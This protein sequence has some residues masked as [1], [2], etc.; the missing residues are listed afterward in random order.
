MEPTPR[1]PTLQDIAR[2]AGV[3]AMTVS[4]ALKNSPL[5]RPETCRRIQNIARDMGWRPNPLVSALMSHLGRQHQV[6]STVNLAILDPRSEDYT[7]NGLYVIGAKRQAAEL[8]YAIEVFPYKP[9][10]TSPARLRDILLARG[11]RGVVL[12]PVPTAL[13]EIAFDFTGFAAVTIGYSVASPVLPRVA[14]DIQNTV[15]TALRH[16]ES[17]GYQRVGLIMADDANRRML[18]LY[19]GA[20][21]TYG[22][23]FARTMEAKELILPDENFSPANLKKI[24][25]WIKAHKIQ[26][27]LTSAFRLYDALIHAGVRIPDDFAFVH[28]HK[29]LDPRVTSIDQ[30]RDYVGHKAVD[31]VTAMIQRNESCPVPY[32]Q[33]V[34]TPSILHKGD[35]SPYYSASRVAPVGRRPALRTVKR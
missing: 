13:S 19:S 7:A 31:L 33:T 22:S 12:M 14:N 8:G 30:M 6:R 26:G 23:F 5:Q 27:I 20:R 15:Y 10:A 24:L 1:L 18:Y 35:T 11:V 4:R 34:L 32:P 16:L 21:S 29:Y 17:R 9:R 2:A 25:S 3:S 28:L